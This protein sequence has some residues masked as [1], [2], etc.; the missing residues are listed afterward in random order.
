MNQRCHVPR[1]SRWRPS[2]VSPGR[3]HPVALTS[4]PEWWLLRQRWHGVAGAPRPQQSAVLSITTYRKYHTATVSSGCVS[5]WSCVQWLF[6]AIRCPGEVDVTLFSL[7]FAGVHDDFLEEDHKVGIKGV[8]SPS[9][10]VVEKGEG[11]FDREATQVP[12]D[13]M[14]GFGI[15]RNGVG[16]TWRCRQVKLHLT[17]SL[18]EGSL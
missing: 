16:R 7:G 8:N 9:L 15:V 3:N 2:P 17:W 11:L 1:R 5:L 4:C 18:W 13:N 10:H 14:Q 12:G 6:P